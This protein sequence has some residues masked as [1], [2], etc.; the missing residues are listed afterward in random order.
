MN[1]ENRT[2]NI[3]SSGYDAEVELVLM[4]VNNPS[5]MLV[6]PVCHKHSIHSRLLIVVMK[7]DNDI[8]SVVMTTDCC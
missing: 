5:R 4:P 1:F 2:L 7:V 3:R 6:V 8:T